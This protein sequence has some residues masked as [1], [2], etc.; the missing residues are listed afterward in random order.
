MECY[1]E[2]KPNKNEISF[3]FN[4]GCINISNSNIL[5]KF[6]YQFNKGCKISKK[7]YKL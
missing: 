1:L 6:K 4:K 7:Q 2:Y 3:H 5:K